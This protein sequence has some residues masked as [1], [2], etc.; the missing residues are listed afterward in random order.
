M[1]EYGELLILPTEDSYGW[2]FND[3]VKRWARIS[4]DETDSTPSPKEVRSK[5]EISDPSSL[6]VDFQGISE[7]KIKVINPPEVEFE[8]TIGEYIK[9]ITERYIPRPLLSEGEVKKMAENYYGKIRLYN[10]MDY[11]ASYVREQIEFAYIAG[12]KASLKT[13]QSKQEV[14]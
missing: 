5:E 6:Y 14:K 3:C 1:D 7:W 9:E 10:E 12:Y 2:N 13:E 4:L 11:P 8:T